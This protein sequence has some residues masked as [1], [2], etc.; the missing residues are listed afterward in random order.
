ME[1]TEQLVGVVTP[2]VGRP[3][4]IYPESWYL[5]FCTPGYARNVPLHSIRAHL[6]SSAMSMKHSLPRCQGKKNELLKEFWTELHSVT[7][8]NILKEKAKAETT[9]MFQE[10]LSKLTKRPRQCIY[11][12]TGMEWTFKWIYLETN[13]PEL[14][15]CFLRLK[16]WRHILGNTYHLGKI[17]HYSSFP[18]V[19]VKAIYNINIVPVLYNFKAI[20]KS[21]M[22][23]IFHI[24]VATYLDLLL[25][26]KVLK[27]QQLSAF[28]L[29]IKIICKLQNTWKIQK[30]YE[31]RNQNLIIPNSGM[32]IVWFLSDFCP[33]TQQSCDDTI[34]VAHSFGFFNFYLYWG[35]VDEQ[36][37]SF[38]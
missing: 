5:Y 16:K 18:L 15:L 10:S 24:N 2:D 30:N 28:I 22:A 13:E 27:K 21:Y 32:V 12:V 4:F 29:F 23:I 26:V 14:L 34:Y 1:W 6:F 38:K 11:Y 35:I 31:E 7:D 33:P 20:L 17:L 25:K 37:D 19:K 9:C 36:C 3:L 8:G